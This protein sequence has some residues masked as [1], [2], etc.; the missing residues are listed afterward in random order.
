MWGQS[1][2]QSVSPISDEKL[3]EKTFTRSLLSRMGGGG[4]G[5][6]GGGGGALWRN[7]S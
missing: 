1:V 4:G 6:S 7:L 5:G 3:G 2:S